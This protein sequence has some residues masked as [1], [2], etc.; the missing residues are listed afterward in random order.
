MSTKV[1]KI[2]NNTYSLEISIP[3]KAFGEAIQKAYKKNVKRFNVPGFRKGK[4]PF[5]IVEQY[6]GVEVFYD[7][8]IN[9]AF[10]SLYE[11]AI[12]DNELEPVDR[13]EVEIKRLEVDKPVILKAK[14]TVKPEVKLG[15]YKGI[16]VKKTEYT[17]TD[18][19]VDKELNVK[20]EQNARMIDVEDRAVEDGDTITFDFEGFVDGV[21]FDGGKAEKHKLTIGS[22]QFIPGFEEQMV[23]KKIGEEAEISVKF[24]EEYQAEELKG[25]DA[26]F[27]VCVHAIQK[28]ELPELDDEFAKDISEKDTLDEVKAD[29]KADLQKRA[30]EN[31][32]MQ[33]QSNVIDKVLEGVEVDIP[34]CMIEN[35]IDNIVRD[36]E[37]RLSYSGMTL[38]KYMEYS[39]MTM[40]AFRDQFKEQAE[41]Q[42]KTSL[43][44]EK[45]AKEENVEATQEE[46][47]KEIEKMAEQYKM[48]VDKVKDL[49]QG[50]YLDSLKNDIAVNKTVDML[51]EQAKFN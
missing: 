38:Q 44:I 24:P 47:D 18:E 4:A 12:K 33:D 23:G 7:D 17:V 21:P 42:V 19:D 14:V 2:D 51:V 26:T 25:K 27:K 37:M 40:E 50:E 32:K 15:E 16:E 11:K 36:F 22:H 45:I 8:A 29:I 34:A 39:G 46:I 49:M 3:K 20:R 1:E 48:E 30:E 43:V 31:A 13:P 28:R 41:K 10:P 35:Q 5:K 6:Y 9:F